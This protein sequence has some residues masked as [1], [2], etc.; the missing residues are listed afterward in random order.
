MTIKAIQNIFLAILLLLIQVTI[1]NNIHLFGCCTPLLFAYIII[2]MGVMV[3]RWVKLVSGFLIGLAFDSFSNT[4]GVGAASL[5]FLA[6]I[7]PMI[8]QLYTSHDNAD[9]L[10]PALQVMGVAKYLVYLL[11]L[12]TFFSLVFYALEAFS[13]SN[14]AE[15]ALCVSGSMAITF[16]II[17]VIEICRRKG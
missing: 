3:P 16:I 5:T 8:L 14:L 9:T 11:M 7:Q 10:V 1:L 13:F 15:W 4:P 2:R 12:L 17:L 6:F